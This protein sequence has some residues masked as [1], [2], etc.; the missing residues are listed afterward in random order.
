MPPIFAKPGKPSESTL[1]FA[2]AMAVGMNFAFARTVFQDVQ[3]GGLQRVN[4][5]ALPIYLLLWNAPP[6]I[7]FSMSRIF[8]KQGR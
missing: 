6:I 1:F 7:F 8:K 2:I 4:W 5:L 3:P